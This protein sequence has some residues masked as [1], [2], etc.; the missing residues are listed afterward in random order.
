MDRKT[1]RQGSAQ[2]GC[3]TKPGTQRTLAPT[4][5]GCWDPPT[6]R[7]A[8]HRPPRCPQLYGNSLLKPRT[9]TRNA[10]DAELR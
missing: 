7:L 5:A 10:S 3:G 2:L 6:R 4:E 8:A 1:S 9:Y